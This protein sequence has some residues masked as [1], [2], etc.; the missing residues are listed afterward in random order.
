MQEAL[1]CQALGLAALWEVGRVALDVARSRIDLYVVWRANTAAYP[2]CSAAEQ[3]LYD[4]RQRSWRQLHFFQF[5]AHV[6]CELPRIACRVC[7]ATTQLEVPW[8]REGSRFTLQLAGM[9]GLRRLRPDVAEIKRIYFRPPHLRN[10]R[11]C[12]LLSR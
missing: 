8:A 2:A 7:G 6:H 11:I 12:R 3:K 10:Q 9:G 1:F 5:E 4:H